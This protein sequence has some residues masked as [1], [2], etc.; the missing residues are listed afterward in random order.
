MIK[1]I[2]KAVFKIITKIFGTI[3]TPLF[4]AIS[5]LFPNL[6][7]Y[8]QYIT[9]FIDGALTYFVTACRLALIPK[10]VLML[11]FTYFGIKFTIYVAVK[12]YKFT[13]FVYEKLKPQGG[14]L[15]Y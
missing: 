12:G 6:S 9:N 5:V 2:I 14:Y 13:L 10:E 7:S 15:C 3:F 1:K 11:L 8:F 4:S